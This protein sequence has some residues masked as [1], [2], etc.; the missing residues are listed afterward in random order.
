LIT[1][2]RARLSQGNGAGVS[3]RRRRRR[4]AACGLLALGLLTLS[5]A[6]LPAHRPP[7]VTAVEVWSDGAIHARLGDDGEE[8]LVSVAPAHF[9]GEPVIADD[10]TGGYLVVWER[11]AADGAGAIV[12]RRLDAAAQPLGDEIAVSDAAAGSR[13]GPAVVRDDAGTLWV[14]WQDHRA[15]LLDPDVW[16]R[17]LDRAGR[18]LGPELLVN[19]G[20]AWQLGYQGAP[21]LVSHGDGTVSVVWDT[22]A[23]TGHGGSEGISAQRLAADGERIGGPVALQGGPTLGLPPEVTREDGRLLLVWSLPDPQAG[24][25]TRGRFFDDAWRPLGDAFA[26]APAAVAAAPVP[27]APRPA[28]ALDPAPLSP[29]VF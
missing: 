12:G 2:H 27:E 8:R 5:S 15:G 7:R 9:Q 24:T 4:A 17:R 6:T 19:A 26:T 23:L 10:G 11:S 1:S 3:S 29:D 16:A 21:A 14:A 13:G 18:A 20:A 25:I 22:F 28:P